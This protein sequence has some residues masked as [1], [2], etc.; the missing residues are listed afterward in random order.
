MVTGSGK[1]RLMGKTLRDPAAVGDLIGEG[2]AGVVT[3]VTTLVKRAEHLVEDG[4]VR[5]SCGGSC[6]K[7][8]VP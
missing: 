7:A 5:F 1:T 8:Q 4:E 6:T 3:A 2:E